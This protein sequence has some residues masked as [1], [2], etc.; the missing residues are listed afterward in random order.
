MEHEYKLGFRRTK[1]GTNV[2]NFSDEPHDKG[3][4][5]AHIEFDGDEGEVT[6]F[7]NDMH[8]DVK[9]HIEAISIAINDPSIGQ[10]NMTVIRTK[11]TGK[12][13]RRCGR[14]VY[15]STIKQYTWQCFNCDEDFYGFE[16]D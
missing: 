16:I 13:C 7:D 15:R 10:E 2:R 11:P 5:V 3:T 9:E 1:N 6:F 8:D 4:I 12:F 14:P